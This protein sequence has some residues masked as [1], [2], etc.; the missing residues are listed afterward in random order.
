MS[1]GI[2]RVSLNSFGYGGTN[3]HVILESAPSTTKGNPF[4]ANGEQK[5]LAKNTN[6]LSNESYPKIDVS[7]ANGSSSASSNSSI[8]NSTI[9]T[10]PDSETSSIIDT[11]LPS[12]NETSAV[13]DLSKDTGQKSKDRAETP[14]LIVITANSEESLRA[15]IKSL[16]QWTVACEPTAFSI[17]NLSYTLAI[18]RSLFRWRH[19]IVAATQEE[20]A[21]SLDNDKPRVSRMVP[22]LRVA[23]VFTGQG[24]QWHAMGRE[25]LL[26]PTRFRDSIMKSDNILKN[27]G[28]QW[29][30]EEELSKDESIS[31]VGESEV[32]QPSTTAVQIA[33]VELL[34]SLGIRPHSVCGHSSGEI[35][36]AYAAGALSHQG[37][38]E[39][40]YRRGVWS[41]AAKELNSTKGAMIAVGI[42]EAAVLPYV[43]QTK[44]GLLTVACVNSPE[45]TT[46]SGDVAA[47]DELKSILD[48][49]GIFNRKLKVDSAY[50]SHHMKKVADQYQKS[51]EHITTADAGRDVAFFSSV[52]GAKKTSNFGPAYWTQNLV[53][54]VRFSDAVK[55]VSA[56]M[57]AS[58]RSGASTNIFV[59]IG[60]HSALSGP[61]RQSLASTNLK[62]LYISALLRGKNAL[63]TVSE[64]AGQLFEN[65]YPLDLKAAISLNGSNKLPKAVGDLNPYSWDH[66]TTFWHE[67]RLS[68]EHRLRDF[69]HHDLLGLLDVNSN[70]HEP[71]WRYHI[72]VDHIPWL[73]DHVI[74]GSVIFPG[75]GY[76]CMA[77][78]AMKQITE[79]RKTPG[80]IIKYILR[81]ITFSKPIVVPEPIMDGFTPETEVQLTLSPHKSTDNSR[82][83]SFRIFSFSS[84]GVW[85]EHCSGR[86]SV[87][88]IARIDD[89]EG[90]REEEFL[91]DALSGQMESIRDACNNSIDSQKFYE[92]M[93]T[94]GNNFGPMFTVLKEIN[95]GACKGYTK[96]AI[97]DVASCMPKLFMEPHVIHP[98]TLDALNQL[99]AGLFKIYCSNSPLMP[100]YTSEITVAANMTTRAGQELLVAV[101][102]HPEGPRSL[103]G[104]CW[105][106]QKN[107]DR[108]LS[109]VFT[110]SGLQLRGIGD[111]QS[112]DQDV[113]FQRK[114]T[115]KLEWVA[116]ED[117]HTTEP[118]NKDVE[119][120]LI[121][122]ATNSG[123]LKGTKTLPHRKV[124]LLSESNSTALQQL[125]DG[126]SNIFTEDSCQCSQLP[127]DNLVI[128]ADA[129]YI[130]LDDLAHP[131]L[132]EPSTERF[133]ALKMLFMTTKS[134]MW[135]S[136][137]AS[138]STSTSSFKGLATGLAR[139][140][141]RENDGMNFVTIDIQDALLPSSLDVPAIVAQVAAASFWPLDNAQASK[142]YEYAYSD[143]RLLVPRL[144]KDDSFDSWVDRAVKDL[145]PEM[146]LYHQPDRPMQL[147]VETPGLLSSL[148][149]IDDPLAQAHLLPDEIEIEARAYGI[150]FKDVY[151]ALGQMLPGVNMVGEVA[152][153][154]TAIGSSFNY[155]FRVGD[156]VAAIGARPFASRARVNGFQACALPSSMPFTIGASIP[157]VFLTAYQCI[158]EVAHLRK[159]QTILIHAASGGV[160][161]AAIMLS[162]N[163]GAEIF[164]TVGSVSKRQLLIDKYN[165]PESHIFSTRSRSFKQ[166][167]L[168]LT[169]SKGVDVVLN[170]LSGEWLT[171]SWECIARLGTFV[172]IGK[173]DIY[174][175]S[176]LSMVP[177]D[178]S[179]TFAA[180]DLVVLFEVR[181]EEM[182]H[183][184]SKIISMFENGTL[185][186]LEPVTVMPMTN[187][188]DA[189]RVIS[190]RKHTGK[191]VLEVDNTTTVNAVP[192]RPI[193]L[194]LDESWTYV[195]AGGLGDLG[196]RICLL[197]ASHGAKHVLTL[198]RRSLDSEAREA[199]Q[200]QILSLGAV[201]H[202]V[203]CD[204]TQASDIIEAALFCREKLP[205][206]KGV[207][208]AGMVLRVS[209]SK[210][211]TGLI[212]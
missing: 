169:K 173:A 133:E 147:H 121:S 19:T 129:H 171:D 196:K 82:W 200:S 67:S 58:K 181:P 158:V 88:M 61:L 142:E 119:S 66:S 98:T 8:G 188:E 187:M 160:G 20:L 80:K 10:L 59:E 53:S 71:R 153:V 202:V 13:K 141:R 56:D 96:L 143:G 48:K 52:T 204:I 30:L 45:S 184:F 47:I 81:D 183:R 128:D 29:S 199:F 149:F 193:P 203:K 122:S 3:A 190:S 148:R 25:L 87:E 27:A 198:S 113:P 150:N 145:E 144:Q 175:R 102:V 72:N 104:N 177:F 192:L 191:V 21:S 210:F 182:S 159:G 116:T 93:K 73:K 166:G 23:F 197:L 140:V 28:C 103:T 85:H 38:I 44:K 134:L 137:Q 111:A 114:M 6:S 69:P 194:K 138:Q 105:A 162:Q 42:G 2:Q 136:T 9:C 40:A 170:S 132:F 180:V 205:P 54:K 46:I 39:A 100:V 24:A 151:I 4:L 117:D 79:I 174:H 91:N 57:T 168:R 152:G 125:G 156:R 14:K 161:Q 84:D 5:S 34:V 163:I 31:R 94:S 7:L 78:E 106:F 17:D 16:H 63:Q 179:V 124:F 130:V 123:T 131:I 89:V 12:K 60:P 51:L 90:R 33:L 155:Q 115:Y 68:R 109:S 77:I 172:E 120:P 36:A 1:S 74:E 55:L 206:V 195:V 37:A 18:R 70:I 167:V 110:T 108:S 135:I 176:Q 208:H 112:D 64:L 118:A 126:I 186:T 107:E 95:V 43:K 101:D 165:I 35:A 211:L 62:Y 11:E 49:Q 92:D 65:G 185:S 157:T 32:S 76:L 26:G 75:S 86:I 201:V 209:K 99:I 207:I 97:P 127:W 178:K 41:A 50:H 83:E 164:A 212:F 189:F 154:V 139:V 15:N 146:V 22:K